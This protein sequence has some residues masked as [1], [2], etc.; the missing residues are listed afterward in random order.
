[1][2]YLGQD[3]IVLI[4][5]DDG[6]VIGYRT[7]EIQR[8]LDQQRDVFDGENNLKIEIPVR[9]FLHRNVGASAWGLAIHREARMIAISA[10]TEK[11][12]VIAY[13]LAQPDEDL[14]EITMSSDSERVDCSGDE[15]SEDFPM[16]RRQDHTITLCARHNVPSVSFNNSGDDPSGR[17]LSSCSING[18]TLIWDLHNPDKQV[19]TIRLGFCASVKDPTKAPKLSPG[20]CA[21]LRPS[22]VPHAIWSTMFLDAGTAYE[23]STMQDSTAP[24]NQP[25]PYIRDISECKSKFSLK[26]RK[27]TLIP[28]GS[29]DGISAGSVAST[30]NISETGSAIPD[31]GELESFAS[32]EYGG[33]E[34]LN[35]SDESDMEVDTAPENV[36][37]GPLASDSSVSSDSE[38]DESSSVPA[39][40]APIP[41][42]NALNAYGPWYQP[43]ENTAT[44]VWDDNEDDS[45]SGDELF[46]PTSAQVHMAFT[47]AIQPAR[48]YCEII[49]AFTLARQVCSSRQC[50]TLSSCIC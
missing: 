46:I 1:M 44:I 16:P 7:E 19:R 8:V 40:Q 45:E 9:T 12:T 26:T 28:S 48:A 17:W 10:N 32:S 24:P 49:T 23:D 11:V 41:P 21:C 15:D 18:E 39:P 13:A 27:H 42:S 20:T 6:D 38:I 35:H 14:E 25:L 33:S 31:D 22:N 47:N 43:P 2:D 50:Q 30:M 3:E 37:I 36:G 34:Q 29:V 4:T 5:C